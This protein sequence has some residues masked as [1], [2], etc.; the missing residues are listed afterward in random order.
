MSAQ[1][2]AGIQ[3]LLEAEKEAQKTVQRARAY[4]TQKVK[5]ARA[6]AQKE[7][8][9]YKKQKEAEFKKFEAEH[10]G[11]NAKA[12]EEAAKEVEETLVRIKAIGDE[13]TPAVVEDLL[14]A[15]VDVKPQ[16]HRNAAPTA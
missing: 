2:S 7:I 8:E 4:R 9:Q 15:T 3:T 11:V 12:E 14:K 10:S 1:N 5:D 6:E 16:P 13:K